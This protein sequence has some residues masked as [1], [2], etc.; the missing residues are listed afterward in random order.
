MRIQRITATEVMVPI[1]D[2]VVNSVSLDRPLHKLSVA[3]QPGWTV[4]FDELPKLVLQV[5]LDSGV[6]ALGECYRGHDWNVVS[7]ICENLLGQSLMELDRQALPIA[8]CREY[9]GFECA[10]WDGVAKSHDLRLVDLLGGVVRDRILVGAWSGHRV[11]DEVGAL[12]RRFADRGYTCIKFKCDLDDDVVGWCREVA[13][14]A[15]GMKVILDPN[16]RWQHPHE[17]RRRIDELA[18]IGNVLCLEDPIPRWMMSEYRAL[19]HYSSIPIVL[20]LSL[21]Y[22]VHGQRVQDAILAIQQQ[23]VDAFN[24]NCGIARFQQLDHIAMA[25]NLA[26]WHGSEIDLGILEAMYVHCCAAAHSCT[27][28]SDIF[29]RMIRVHD[30]LQ[31]P[32]T[33]QPPYVELPQGYGLGVTLDEAALQQY[34]TRKEVFA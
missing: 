5:E 20:H 10:I 14:V 28:P 27:L 2:G 9:D 17:V 13:R 32:L 4:Q 24:F 19:K 34:Q 18:P 16:E 25:A 8:H 15:P 26:C 30:L 7:A 3:G 23:A 1:H 21:P 22:I 29:G 33:F 31:Q 6:V 11:V 12:A